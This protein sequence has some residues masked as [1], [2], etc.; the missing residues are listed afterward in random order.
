MTR[1]VKNHWPMLVLLAALWSPMVV[2]LAN[3]YYD[4][5]SFPTTGSAA[6][7]AAMR[8]ELDLISAGFDKLPSFS[9]NANEIVTVNS[10]A[11]ALTSTATPNVSNLIF[12]ATQASSVGANTLDDYEEGTWTPS[13]GG[14]ATYTTQIGFYTKIGNVVTVHGHLVINTIGTGSAATITALPFPTLAT[15]HFVT[16]VNFSNAATANLVHVT[17][18][19]SSSTN[20]ALF[21]YVQDGTTTTTIMGNGTSIIFSGSYLTVT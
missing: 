12:P 18:T 20:F 9:G 2:A 4:H 1:F 19:A 11:T 3:D 21:G 15:S 17:G 10:G 13:V 16:A 7:S 8:A 14:T 5:G 6:T